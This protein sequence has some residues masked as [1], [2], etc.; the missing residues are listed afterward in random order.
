MVAVKLRL[1][2]ML[3]DAE[4]VETGGYKV[5][6]TLDWDAQKLAEKYVKAGAVLPN[7]RNV[8]KY[9]AARRALGIRAIDF[10]W[11][12][13]LRASSIHNAALVAAGLPHR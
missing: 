12:N 6:T 5:I 9:L 7:I 3:S 13:G 10:G 8:S 1:D 4:P 11:I 2:Q